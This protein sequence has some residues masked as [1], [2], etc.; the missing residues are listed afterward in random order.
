VL[1]GESGDRRGVGDELRVIED[2]KGVD[3]PIV[4]G[5]KCACIL[6]PEVLIAGIASS[7]PCLDTRKLQCLVEQWLLIVRRQSLVLPIL[8]PGHDCNLDSSLLKS[9]TECSC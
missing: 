4:P 6:R 9:H 7:Y 3:M 8:K 1:C 5:R 2:D